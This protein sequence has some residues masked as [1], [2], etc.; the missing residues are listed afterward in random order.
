[1]RVVIFV[2]LVCGLICLPAV[3]QTSNPTNSQSAARSPRVDNP[4]VPGSPKAPD[5]VCFG[6]Y[7]SWSIQFINGE[8]RYLA[9]NEPD[10]YFSGNFYWVPDEKVWNWHRAN[11]LAPADGGY[12]LSASIQQQ[13]C[14]DDVLKASLPYSAQV[15]LPQGDMVSGCCRKLKPGEAPV[16][17]HGLPTRDVAPNVVP[18]SSPAKSQ[19]QAGHPVE[20]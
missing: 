3:A 9:D 2:G 10:R 15:Y 4:A 12:A 13:A 8:A 5:M 11:G 16:G 1:M 14:H 7:P 19:P 6:Y 18:P 17:R 20:Q